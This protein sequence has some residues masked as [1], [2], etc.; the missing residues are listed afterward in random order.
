MDSRTTNLKLK[1]R[2]EER[3]GIGWVAISDDPA[4]ETIEA[5]TKVELFEKLREKTAAL[6]GSQLPMNFDGADGGLNA[7][8]ADR[9]VVV[10]IETK[11]KTAFDSSPQYAAEADSTP[12][13]NQGSGM[14]IWK[15][16]FFVLLAL[17]IGWFVIHNR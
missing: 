1:Y 13:A 4:S 10:N 3:P 14:N 15:V 11:R 17:V 8:H 9:N 5:A 2:I 16:L 12:L 7:V 6:L